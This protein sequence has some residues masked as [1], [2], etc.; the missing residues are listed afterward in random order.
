M[1]AIK[2]AGHTSKIKIGMDAAVSE[3]IK[4]GYIILRKILNTSQPAHIMCTRG[5][6][7]LP[8]Q[9]SSKSVVAQVGED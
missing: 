7:G 6:L 1:E 9:P 8:L 5:L 2:K 4:N 3:F